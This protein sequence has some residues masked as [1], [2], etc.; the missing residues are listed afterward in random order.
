MGTA[1]TAGLLTL[2]A[3]GMFGFG[4][5]L[6]PLYDKFCEITGIGGRTAETAVTETLS[7][8][9]DESR[10][11]TV[12]F[13][14]NVNSGLP[15]AFEPTERMMQ[16]HPGKMYETVYIA[17]NRSDRTLV[18]QAVPS[19]APGLASLYFNKTECFCFTEQVLEPGESREMPVRFFVGS[20][21]PERTDLITLSYIIYPNNDASDALAATN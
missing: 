12:H 21:L 20:D 3:I 11:V 5:L 15:W 7:T 18:A 1:R 14:A 17:H 6:V 8:E 13:D 2:V 16:V 19:V 4:Y 10:L 9:I